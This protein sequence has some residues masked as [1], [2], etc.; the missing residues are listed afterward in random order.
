MLNA[1]ELGC[2][3]TGAVENSDRKL[4]VPALDAVPD[5]KPPEF[6]P[7]PAG[8]EPDATVQVLE[9]LPPLAPKVKL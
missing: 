6:K 2:C 7:K 4:L 1:K 5:S 9:P 3:A 8:K